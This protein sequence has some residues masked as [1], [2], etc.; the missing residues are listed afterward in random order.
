M[1]INKFWER[2]QQR[3]EVV[4]G[5]AKA[6]ATF[7]NT[8]VPYL[9]LAESTINEGCTV[10]R[11]GRV[12]I[13]KPMIV[14][15]DD[16]P[17]FEGFEFDKEMDIDSRSVETF[18]F[19][20]GIRFPSLKYLNTVD[21]LDLE[22]RSLARSVRRHKNRFEREENVNTTLLV[23][24][25]DCWQFSVLLYMAELVARCAKSDIVNLLNKYRE[26]GA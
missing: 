25:E 15:P 4:R 9:F 1:D 12:T 16:M 21:D 10:V 8:R 22:N 17:R 20:R 5:R 14:L 18:F 24:P 2:A 13:E 23:G 7:R 6:L 19:L 3:T 11:K 26:D